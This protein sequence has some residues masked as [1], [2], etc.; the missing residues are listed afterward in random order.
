[1]SS[2]FSRDALASLCT[3]SSS[4]SELLHTHFMLVVHV[5]LIERVKRVVKLLY[6][7]A[8]I[9]FTLLMMHIVESKLNM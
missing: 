8:L 6:I 2:S 9:S 7:F 5:Y 3:C 4:F 1:M